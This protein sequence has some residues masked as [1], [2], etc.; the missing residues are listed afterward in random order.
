MKEKVLVTH[1]GKVVQFTYPTSN[2]FSFA[3][4][5]LCINTHQKKVCVDYHAIHDE[6]RPP[7]RFIN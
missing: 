3:N 2:S 1:I 7:T 4:S 5:P 6:I